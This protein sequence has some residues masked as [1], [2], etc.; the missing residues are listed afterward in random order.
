MNIAQAI[1]FFNYWSKFSILR[2]CIFA[3]IAITLIFLAPY[4]A[5]IAVGVMLGMEMVIGLAEHIFMSWTISKIGPITS[6]GHSSELANAK[7][8]PNIKLSD[9]IRTEERQRLSANLDKIL[10]ITYVKNTEQVIPILDALKIL[11]AHPVFRILLNTI[12]QKIDDGKKIKIR[13]HETEDS[14]GGFYHPKID[15]YSGKESHDVHVNC[16]KRRKGTSTYTATAAEVAAHEFT[17]LICD[18]VFQNNSEPFKKGDAQGKIRLQSAFLADYEYCKNT[19]KRDHQQIA[20]GLD[21]I[22]SMYGIS[23]SMDDKYTEDAAFLITILAVKGNK[24]R[25]LMPNC[26]DYLVGYLLPAIATDQDKELV[27][28]LQNDSTVDLNIKNLASNKPMNYLLET[29]VE[30]TIKMVEDSRD[31][32]MIPDPK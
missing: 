9:H 8:M 6:H 4:V 13:F 27:R 1:N 17:H 19:N 26:W 2:A 12:A 10:D 30:K 14:F 20:K 5:L 15:Q 29:R 24:I 18:L 31:F 3:I 23:G 11:N 16:N 32:L 22:Y 25:E 21:A 28:E 7:P